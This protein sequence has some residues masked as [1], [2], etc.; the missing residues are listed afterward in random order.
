MHKNLPATPAD[1][2]EIS[3][4]L[5][6][7]LNIISKIAGV[8]G[9]W[10]YPFKGAAT[11]FEEMTLLDKFYW[12]YKCEHP[13]VQPERGTSPTFLS[14]RNGAIE[15][16][17]GFNKETSVSL[18]AVGDL[19]PSEGLEYSKD[20]LYEHVADLIFDSTISYASL[21]SPITK[22]E[23][24]KGVI[25]DKEGP[26]ECCSLKQF[27]TLNGHKGKC[28]TAIHT[29]TNHMFD[30]GAEGVETTLDQLT[31]NGIV[32][33]GTNRDPAEAS[34]SKILDENG[35][36]VGFVSASF[37]LNGRNPPQKQAHLINVAKLLPKRGP[38]NLSLL[39]QQIDHC[40]EEECDLI[41]ASLHWG[42][43]FEFFPRKRQ[44]E[45][46][47]TLIEWGVDVIIAHHPHVVQ[48][49][50]YYQTQR[51]PNRMA[52]IAY[53]LGSLIWGFTAPHLALSTILRLSFSKGIFQGKK[54][55]FIESAE[56]IPVF[57]S[58]VQ[59]GNGRILTR[60]EK[61]DGFVAT[62]DNGEDADRVAQ[63]QHFANIVLRRKVKNE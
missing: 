43:E 3:I 52:V 59:Y 15:L 24:K 7:G 44:I 22:Q 26:I 55:T 2:L 56:V 4:A 14:E 60:I 39:K 42:F 11:D 45:V 50:E 57:R 9:F 25:S 54:A 23:L 19:I 33:V 49:V 47:H 38:P 5:R 53:S 16:P 61:L 34:K 29:A 8:F 10:D 32:G 41:I 37:G 27:E 46:A 35:I 17:A 51:D 63:I 18:S 62:K 13:V 30:M 21:E 31:R 36:K 20:I 6:V 40:R 1:S 48:P 58:Y 12:A 28:F